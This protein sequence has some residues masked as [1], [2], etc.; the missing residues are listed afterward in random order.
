[1]LNR[2]HLA[3]GLPCFHPHCKSVG[4][5]AILLAW[6]V[7]LNSTYLDSI[8]VAGGLLFVMSMEWRE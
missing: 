1:M 3:E 4:N 5:K 6:E 2:T 7:L 8:S